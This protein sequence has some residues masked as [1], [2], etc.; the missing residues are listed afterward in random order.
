MLKCTKFEFH[1]GSTPDAARGANS[2][3]QAAFKGPTSKGIERKRLRM[4]RR[5]RVRMEERGQ[6]PRRE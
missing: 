1:W 4:R 3:P 5:V 6:S 2:A